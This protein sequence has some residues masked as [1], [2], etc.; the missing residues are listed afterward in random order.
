MKIMALFLW[1]VYNCLIMSLKLS[2]VI[3]AYNEEK[4]IGR[5][6]ESIFENTQNIFFEVIVVDNGS[7]DGTLGVVK[8]FSGVKIVTESR[9]G[10]TRARQRGFLESTGDMVCFVDADSIIPKDWVEK[11][12]REFEKGDLV[13]LSGPY[14]YYDQS[15]LLKFLVKYFY[16][17]LLALPTY[18][19]V[20]YMAISGNLA[21]R[22]SVLE[23]MEGLNT[24][25]EFYGDDADTVRRASE[26]GKVKFS[27]DF[28]MKSSSRRLAKQGLFSTMF[29]YVENFLSEVFF[30]KPVT[31]EYQDFR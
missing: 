14:E 4:Y 2:L 22:R 8:K 28:V 12:Q 7:S 21:I 27:M 6:L 5:C 26:F 30:K 25:I 29:V 31:K 1:E 20:G 16:W 23:K 10:V 9:K 19:V 3:P 15:S 24:E 13:C 18:W 17:Y 11:V